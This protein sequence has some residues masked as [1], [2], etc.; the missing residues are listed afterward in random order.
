M[1]YQA[2]FELRAN[3]RPLSRHSTKAKA[4]AAADAK[5]AASHAVFY[6]IHLYAKGFA[7]MTVA[8]VDRKPQQP[9]A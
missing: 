4:I 3:G 7:G 5:P 9:T 6:S 2:D 8:F 1:T